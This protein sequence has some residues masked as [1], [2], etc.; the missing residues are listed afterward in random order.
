MRVDDAAYRWAL[1]RAVFEFPPLLAMER[2][3]LRAPQ[4]FPT[5][6]SSGGIHRIFIGRDGRVVSAFEIARYRDRADILVELFKDGQPGR[7]VRSGADILFYARVEADR[8]FVARLDTVLRLARAHWKAGRGL[9]KDG[10][11]LVGVPLQE[12]MQLEAVSIRK[13]PGLREH[14]R[15][16]MPGLLQQARQRRIRRPDELLEDRLT[17]GFRSRLSPGARPIG[18]CP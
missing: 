17:L 13:V 10:A 2:N 16:R 12:L 8:V 4:S 14:V 7:L 18:S 15:H 6:D 5:Q 11:V 1:H 3:Y 9:R